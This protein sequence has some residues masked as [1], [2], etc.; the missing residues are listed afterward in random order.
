MTPY[1]ANPQLVYYV[2]Y[3]TPAKIGPEIDS[4]AYCR[5]V[6]SD[7]G[8]FRLVLNV[9]IHILEWLIYIY[10][11]CPNYFDKFSALDKIVYI[12]SCAIDFF[13]NSFVRSSNV[14]LVMFDAHTYR[15]ASCFYVFA[16]CI[17][18]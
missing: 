16:W 11:T 15:I 14:I 1:G 13:S 10:T 12:Y 5:N 17:P 8:L 7:R 9:L 6:I 3:T 4:G 2:S 18:H